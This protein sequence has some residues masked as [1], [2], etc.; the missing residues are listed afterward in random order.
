MHVIVVGAGIIG[1]AT[2]WHRRRLGAVVTII[3]P[4]PAQGAS[5]AAAGM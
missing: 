3:D 1:L 4:T 2:A 5:H